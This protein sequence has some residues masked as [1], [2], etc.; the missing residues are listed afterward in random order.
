LAID[1]L[2]TDFRLCRRTPGRTEDH[3]VIRGAAEGLRSAFA[4]DLPDYQ[5]EGLIFIGVED[6]GKCA[7]LTITEKT[8]REVANWRN[9]GK[10]QPIPTISVTT[11][12][13]DGC[14][15]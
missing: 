11:R 10:V 8:V 2:A 4:N 12:I 13:I 7:N 5:K 9:E 1:R 14:P 6:D 3:V 15:V